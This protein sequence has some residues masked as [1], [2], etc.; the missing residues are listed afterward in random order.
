MNLFVTYSRYFKII[1]FISI[2][3]GLLFVTDLGLKVYQKT[4]R[5]TQKQSYIV[6]TNC[7]LPNPL[8]DIP[9]AD[10]LG[11]ITLV[12]DVSIPG[13]KAPY[14]PAIIAHEEGYLM[15]FRYDHYH[16]KQFEKYRVNLGSNIGCVKLNHQF[17][18]ISESMLVKT[19][20]H[21]SEDPR[22]I[23]KDQNI[24]LL[25][26]ELV[27]ANRYA[28]IMKLALINPESY[29]PEN[30]WTL[31]QGIQS[32]E[33]NWIPFVTEENILHFIY[34]IYPHKVLKASKS[35]TLQL[36]FL[37]SDIQSLMQNIPWNP[38]WGNILHGGTPA[39]LVHGEYL[40]FFH[41]KFIDD[42]KI[43][44]Y[45]MG[46]CTFNSSPPYNVTSI[47]QFPLIFRNIYSMEHSEMA[48]PNLRA[49][50]PTGIEVENSNGKIFI[51]VACGENDS[52]IKLITVD[53]EKLKENMVTLVR[54]P[55]S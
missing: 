7:L 5:I 37:S 54:G 9:L 51:H 49:I 52:G 15:F 3:L 27:P 22:V 28:R 13:I 30:I 29:Q 35:D 50:F 42:R 1:F 31:D 17:C 41:S 55:S 4:S 43:T 19:N 6:S 53:Y 24:Y 20:S 32:I 10:R 25:Y 16:Y 12:T 26:N 39:I 33:K 47:S 45:V 40:A 36:D 34:N 38:E 44:W 2:C 18:P 23:K 8:K 46:A 21:F 48:N 11:I 14:N